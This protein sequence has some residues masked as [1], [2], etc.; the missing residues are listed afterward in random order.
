M[1]QLLALRLFLAARWCPRVHVE[2]A[3]TLTTGSEGVCLPEG[4]V[5]RPFPQAVHTMALVFRCPTLAY[6]PAHY[7]FLGFRVYKGSDQLMVH[8]LFHTL[9]PDLR[10]P[11][12]WWPT[13]PRLECMWLHATCGTGFDAQHATCDTRHRANATRD[14]CDSRHATHA[15]HATREHQ[16]DTRRWKH[17]GWRQGLRP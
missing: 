12:R 7:F 16:R 13:E 4:Y 11:S 8:F 15:T 9:R 6:P 14:A 1:Q 10:G 5:R 2:P 3:N 17:N